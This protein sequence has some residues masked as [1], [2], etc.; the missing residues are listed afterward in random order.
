V[1]EPVAVGLVGAGPWADLVHAPL[2]AGGPHTRLAGIWSRT[3]ARAEELAGKHGAPA[4]ATLDELLDTC[5]A[6]AFAV[7]P[8]AQP[9]LAVRAAR[10]G[11]PLL[12]EKPLGVDLASARRVVDA[13]DEAGVATMTVLSYRYQ[14]TAR[15]FL[16]HAA[17]FDTFGGR[18]VFL[19]GAFLEGPF[20]TGWRLARGC[21]LD[22]GPHLLDLLDAALG[23]VRTVQAAGD[24]HGW[25]SVTLEHDRATTAGSITSQASFC[26]RT[27]VES[28]TEVELFGPAGSLLLDGRAG[29]LIEGFLTMQREFAELVRDPGPHPLDAARN[30]WLQRII[31]AAGTSLAEGGRVGV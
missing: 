15:R 12:L 19:S 26:C 25:V 14:Q 29:D 17:S 7:S 6:V 21:L 22:V 31:A 2:L 23:P 13:V 8:E 10:A 27:R 20:A 4:C 24:V 9:D 18:G 30:L 16:E 1:T 3:A 5:E 28:R 11:K